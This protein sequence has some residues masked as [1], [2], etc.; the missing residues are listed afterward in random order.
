VK[1]EDAQTLL[2]TYLPDWRSNRTRVERVERW[3]SGR[4]NAVDKPSMPKKPT[5]EYRE[6]R[7]RAMTPWLRLVVA[8][9]VQALY[10]EGYRRPQDPENASGWEVWQA[11]GLDARQIAVH[12]S[13]VKHAL[14]FV[15]VIR[16]P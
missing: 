15:S 6:L 12:R 4:L 1:P 7:D 2:G 13:A 8:T 3:Y 10:V 11:N 9:L 5:R 14:S 16:F